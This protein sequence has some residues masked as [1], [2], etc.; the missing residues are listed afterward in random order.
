[1]SI[2]FCGVPHTIEVVFRII[3]SV[4]RLSVHGAVAD[5]CEELASRISDCSASKGRPVAKDKPEIMVAPTDLST[6]TNPLLTN[7]Q[8]R[9][10]LLREYKRKFANLPDDLRLIRFCSDAGFM[11]TV[12]RG[13]YFVIIDEAELAK[14]DCPGSCRGYT[15]P[16]DDELSKVQGCIRGNKKIG[17][18]L[19]VT[20]SNHQG[21]YGIEI[22][23]NSLFR[24]R[25]QSWVMICNGLNKYETEMSEE[26]QENRNDKSG[27]SAAR[28]AAKARPKQTSLP[29]S[30][31]PRVTIPYHMRKWIDVEP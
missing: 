6:T 18:V 22:R 16:R 31:S 24:D 28:P 21:R 19:E 5:M 1:M 20:V 15:L 17:P 30:S 14:L 3:I 2:H 13:Q 25:S 10:N 12:A 9:G 27:A 4:N 23:I 26:I 11:N 8:A 29:M 7:G